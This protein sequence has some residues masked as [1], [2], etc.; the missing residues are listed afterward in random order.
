MRYIV[1]TFRGFRKCDLLS[2]AKQIAIQMVTDIAL[3]G[4]NVEFQW[5]VIIDV[6][7]DTR[8]MVTAPQIMS[9]S[10]RETKV[11]CDD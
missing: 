2:N 10:K 4:F 7:S 11:F 5:A 8:L 9:C 3:D 6:A 1:K